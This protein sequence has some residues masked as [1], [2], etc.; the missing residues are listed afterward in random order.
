MKLYL[1]W[2]C[3]EPGLGVDRVL[4]QDITAGATLHVRARSL[5]NTIP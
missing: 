4:T 5:D 2:E 3:L 1:P